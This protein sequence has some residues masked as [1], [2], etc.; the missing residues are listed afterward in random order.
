MS[1]YDYF[2]DNNITKLWG[3]EIKSIGKK[4]DIVYIKLENGR[5]IAF[6]DDKDG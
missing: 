6:K 1:L 3:K 2:K 4:G 5:I